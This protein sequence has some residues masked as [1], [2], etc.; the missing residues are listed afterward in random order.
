M[1]ICLYIYTYKHIYSYI[2]TTYIY[3]YTYINIYILYMNIY[4]YIYTH[5]CI[6]THIYIHYSVIDLSELNRNNAV[7]ESNN[8]RKEHFNR[9][10]GQMNL[11][12]Y[13]VITLGSS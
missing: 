4:I 12:V 11:L 9:I 10:R 3:K 5:I 2:A 6:Y 7:Y 1:N 13:D 8:Y